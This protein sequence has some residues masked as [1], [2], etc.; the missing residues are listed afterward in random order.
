[1]LAVVAIAEQS[2]R[3]EFQVAKLEQTLVGVEWILQVASSTA[4]SAQYSSLERAEETRMCREKLENAYEGLRLSRSPP[5]KGVRMLEQLE[6]KQISLRLA[7]SPKCGAG[8]MRL[9]IRL[10]NY[11]SRLLLLLPDRRS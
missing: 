11:V 1:M 6:G 9:V 5:T 3:F 4:L 8:G 10:L 7:M 2:L